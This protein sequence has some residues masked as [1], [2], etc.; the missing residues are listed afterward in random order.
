MD[1]CYR[2]MPKFIGAFFDALYQHPTMMFAV[3]AGAAVIAGGWWFKSGNK[4][5]SR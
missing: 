4:P 1:S 2:S 5:E 3:M